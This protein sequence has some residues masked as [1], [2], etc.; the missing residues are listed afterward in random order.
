[1][2]RDMA[3]NRRN[4]ATGKARQA[5]TSL[6][7]YA[8]HRGVNRSSVTRAVQDG[9][10][11]ECIVEHRGRP[12]ISDIELAD[13]EWIANTQ[14]TARVHQIIDEADLPPFAVSHAR[15]EAAKAMKAELE[16]AEMSGQLVR[17]DVVRDRYIDAVGAAK[18]KLLRVPRRAKQRLPHLSASDVRTLDDLVREALEDLAVDR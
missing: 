18:N 5:P 9:R 17:V 15:L 6:T 13:R 3:K 1:M 2:T 14:G 8:K 7:A 10:L 4:K 16:V 11:R 12:A